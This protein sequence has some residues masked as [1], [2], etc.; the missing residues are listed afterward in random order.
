MSRIKTCSTRKVG[1]LTQSQQ[2]IRSADFRSPTRLRTPSLPDTRLFHGSVYLMLVITGW[3]L[4]VPNGAV[5]LGPGCKA[6]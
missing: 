4:A 1:T 6:V 5:C 2:P 3:I